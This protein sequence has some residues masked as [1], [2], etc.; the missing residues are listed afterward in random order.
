MNAYATYNI[1]EKWKVALDII[2]KKKQEKKEEEAD[3][4]IDVEFEEVTSGC[5]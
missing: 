1:L 4:I 5:K 2:D 3:E